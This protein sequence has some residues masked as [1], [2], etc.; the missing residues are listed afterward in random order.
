MGIG[1]DRIDLRVQLLK[2]LVMIGKIFQLG[3]TDKGEICR[4]KEEHG[5]FS[6]D[7][8]VRHLDKGVLMKGVGFER[9]NAGIKH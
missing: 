2:F 6:F 4:I 9:W 1:G 7:A 3:W 8:L 5:P